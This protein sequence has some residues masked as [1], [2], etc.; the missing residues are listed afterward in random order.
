M[1][2]ELAPAVRKIFTDR[3]WQV[4]ISEGSRDDFYAKI[5][6]TRS[7]MEGIASSARSTMRTIREVGYR[8][9]FYMSTLGDFLY[10]FPELPGPLSQ[11]L[12]AEAG[13]LSPHQMSTLV[14]TIR[15]LIE[16]CPPA[17]RSNFLP[18]LL[19]ALFQQVD[20]R[21]SLEWERIEKINKAAGENDD[22]VQEMKDE[23]ILRQLTMA[24]VRL[25]DSL[26]EVQP[27]GKQCTK[28]P[29]IPQ[30]PSLED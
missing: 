2:P 12:F 29:V 17:H 19:T 25:V 1:T 9:L 13:V 18:P 22:L 24:S 6:G 26:L 7:T 8:L 10:S 15:P 16:K 14:D 20:S 30:P 21:A 5:G 3:F 4:G 11:A 27:P 28:M 23:S